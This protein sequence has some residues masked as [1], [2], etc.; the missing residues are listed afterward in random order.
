MVF[1]AS[2]RDV[3]RTLLRVDCRGRW[4]SVFRQ[5]GRWGLSALGAPDSLECLKSFGLGGE[6]SACEWATVAVITAVF[7]IMVATER[8]EAAAMCAGER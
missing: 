8:I 5:G 2:P 1:L 3:N 6:A 7:T 4:G